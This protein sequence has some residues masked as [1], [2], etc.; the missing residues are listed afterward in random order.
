M[1]NLARS[2]RIQLSKCLKTI[3][4]PKEGPYAYSPPPPKPKQN[5]VVGVNVTIFISIELKQTF[6]PNGQK[7]TII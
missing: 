5:R 2:S 1:L 4:A 6:I 7:E 3:A